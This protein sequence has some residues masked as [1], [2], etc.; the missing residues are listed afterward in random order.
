MPWIERIA[1]AVLHRCEEQFLIRIEVHGFRQHP[2][3]HRLEI[4]RT[5]CDDDKVGSSLPRRRLTQSA[6][7]KKLIIDDE[8]VIVDKQHVD[9]RLDIAVLESIVKEDDIH[10]LCLVVVRQPVDA[11]PAIGIHSDI[12]IVELPLHLK[13]LIT[14][15]RHR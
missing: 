13:R 14:N 2:Y 12:D 15:I 6:C 9:S 10:V 5:L 11:L 8:P 7:W 3:V 4:R 1:F